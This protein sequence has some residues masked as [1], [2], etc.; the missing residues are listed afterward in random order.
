MPP[1]PPS[2]DRS[3]RLAPIVIA[4][5]A[6][7]MALVAVL[8]WRLAPRPQAPAAVNVSEARASGDDRRGAGEPSSGREPRRG[9]TL[10][11]I[12]APAAAPVIDEILVEKQEV[13][14]GEENLITVKAH[15]PDGQDDAFLH[16]FIG[17][18]RGRSVPVRQAGPFPASGRPPLEVRVFGRNNVATSAPLPQYTVKA[19]QVDHILFVDAQQVPNAVEEISFTARINATKP[20][21]PPL[22]IGS[23]RWTF[24]DG[25]APVVTG[26]PVV[27]HRFRPQNPDALYSDFLVR[28]EAVPD[29]GPSV[30]GRYALQLRNP[31]F[32]SLYYYK[33]LML[34]VELT[35]R[36]PELGA[37]GRVVQKVRFYHYRSESVT[38]DRVRISHVTSL[39]ENG[40]ASEERSPREALGA[41]EVPPGDGIETTLVLDTGRHP[42]KVMI[43][44]DVEGHTAD[45]V[46]ARGHVSVMRPPA[47]PTPD[48]GDR[49]TDPQ[50]TRRILRARERLGRPFVNHQDLIDLERQGAFADL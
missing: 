18:S 7:L 22:R 49:I 17:V 2:S 29:R 5:G 28:C 1:S 11:P 6:V 36:F 41:F 30:V 23:Y 31:E 3:R 43:D 14:E 35:P 38:L 13:C 12:D 25:G 32:D 44:Y 37:D 15:T 47:T 9:A 33:T 48:N 4:L 40:G 21:G 16:Y 20:G 46:P 45:G 34:S 50:L 26:V 42:N 10:L 24:G 39:T 27:S 19:C 8:A